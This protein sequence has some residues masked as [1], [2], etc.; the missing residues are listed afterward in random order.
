VMGK[1]CS[2]F[3]FVE[4]ETCLSVFHEAKDITKYFWG[5][6]PLLH[7]AVQDIQDVFYSLTHPWSVPERQVILA[8]KARRVRNRRSIHDDII[9]FITELCQKSTH[10]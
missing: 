5:K 4:L 9:S 2:C 8:G 3:F 6:A 1:L 7:F 10:W